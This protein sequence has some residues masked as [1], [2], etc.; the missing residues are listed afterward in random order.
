[1]DPFEFLEKIAFLL[2]NKPT[3]YPLMWENY[4]KT[5]PMP[6]LA[7]SEIS[8]IGKLIQALPEPCALHL[9]NSSTVRYAQLFTVPPRVEICCNRGVNGIEGSCP[10]PSV[11]PPLPAS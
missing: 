11:M 7:Y 5:I 6:D 3:H 4:C 2:D 9:A 8:V 10:P 1:M